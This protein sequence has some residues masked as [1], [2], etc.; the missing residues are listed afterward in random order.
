MV[1]LGQA[2]YVPQ[3]SRGDFNALQPLGPHT[4]NE[5]R[6]ILK[7]GR[8]KKGETLTRPSGGSREM[9]R[10]GMVW[11]GRPAFPN[12]SRQYIPTI[13]AFL[14]LES[15]NCGG[16]RELLPKNTHFFML[17]HAHIAAQYS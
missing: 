12:V 13:A 6:R 8:N 4:K 2:Y 5:A 9:L 10:Y 7:Y 15:G 3:Y 14:L 11:Y 17:R 1:M 16:E